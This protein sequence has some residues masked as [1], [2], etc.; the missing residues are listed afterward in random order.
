VKKILFWMGFVLAAA[1]ASVPLALV[2]EGYGYRFFLKTPGMAVAERQA[3]INPT[4]SGLM[5]LSKRMDIQLPID[6][7]FWFLVICIL[8]ITVSLCRRHKSKSLHTT[9]P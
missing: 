4:G 9:K 5:V 1:V 6:V 2:S 8:G 3:P 7:A